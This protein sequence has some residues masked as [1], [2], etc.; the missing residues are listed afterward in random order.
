MDYEVDRKNGGQAFVFNLAKTPSNFSVNIVLRWTNADN[1]PDW[2]GVTGDVIV[3]YFI[4]KTISKSFSIK[5][6]FN[7]L[8]IIL[9][10]S[11]TLYQRFE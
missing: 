9:S 10:K 2:V 8:I 5:K 6:Q 11:F 3:I 1:E 4:S 7:F